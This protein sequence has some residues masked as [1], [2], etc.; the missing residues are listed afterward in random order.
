MKNAYDFEYD[1]IT[2]SSLGYI[3]CD[4]KGNGSTQT[5]T[6]SQITLNTLP[7]FYGQK[8]E[9]TNASYDNCLETTLQICK[10]TCDYSDITL[11]DKE[12]ASS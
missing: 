12:K 7:M 6:L 2:L 5:S 8:V 3:L 4:F 10:N 9:M 1:G 11:S